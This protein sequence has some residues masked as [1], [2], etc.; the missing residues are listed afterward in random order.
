MGITEGELRGLICFKAEVE[1]I[2][3]L[4]SDGKNLLVR[5]PKKVKEILRLRK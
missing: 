5:I 3:T 4:S 2:S 1:K